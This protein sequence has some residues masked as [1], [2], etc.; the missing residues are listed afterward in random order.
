MDTKHPGEQK[1]LSE[2]FFA[3][4]FYERD[5]RVENISEDYSLMRRDANVLCLTDSESQFLQLTRYTLQWVT[6]SFA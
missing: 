2:S 4:N 5:V 3:G 6:L 1:L